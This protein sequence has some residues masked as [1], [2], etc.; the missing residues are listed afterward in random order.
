M[1]SAINIAG[2]TT[3]A[4]KVTKLNDGTFKVDYTPKKPG[5]YSVSVKID[6][7][8]MNGSP[9]KVKV[10][11]GADINKTEVVKPKNVRPGVVTNF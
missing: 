6:D 8:Q 1:I 4:P 11:S 9:F 10:H 2:P 3:C 7:N 5:N